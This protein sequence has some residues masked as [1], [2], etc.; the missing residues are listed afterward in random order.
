MKTKNI[1][2]LVILSVLCILLLGCEQNSSDR[3]FDVQNTP[4][5][6]EYLVTEPTTTATPVFYSPYSADEYVGMNYSS[7]ESVLRGAGFENITLSA[8]DDID[9][10]S[11][12]KDG[13]VESVL[14]NNSFNYT[15][16]TPFS[17]DE[18]ILIIYHNI[19][20]ISVPVSSSQAAC[21]NYMDIGKLL[22]D[23]GFVNISTDEY[24]D[25][26]AS[27]EYQTVLTADGNEILSNAQIPFDCPIRVVGHYSIPKY[28]VKIDIDFDANQIFN[29]YDVEVSLDGIGLG[30]L[31]HGESGSYNMLL[32][33]GTYELTFANANNNQISGDYVLIVT[34]E[35]TVTCRI[36][37][38]S[39]TIKVVE[40]AFSQDVSSEKILMPF[41]SNYCLRRDYKTI[42]AELKA[43]GFTE[44]TVSPTGQNYWTPSPVDTVVGVNVNGNSAFN[45]DEAFSPNVPIVVY[46]HMADFS[47]AQSVICVTE[48]ETFDIPFTMTSGDSLESLYFEIESPDVLIRNSDGSFTALT[49]GTT[50]VTVFSGNHVCSTCMVEVAEIVVPIESISFVNNEIDVVV[51][52]TFIPKYSVF[53]KNANYMDITP[54]FTSEAIQHISDNQFYANSAGDF[55]I[56]YYQD[57]RLLGVCIVHAHI[58][59]IEEVIIHDGITEMFIGESVDLSFS[60]VPENA[61]CKDIVVTS[62]NPDIV[63][64][65]FDDRGSTIATLSGLSAGDAT[66]LISTPNGK[67]YSTTVT[68]K[69]IPPTKI[70]LTNTT[71]ISRIEIGT[72]IT[73]AVDW[74]P[75]N[76]TVKE[77]TWESSNTDVIKINNDGTILAVGIGTARLTATHKSGVLGTIVLTVEPT[78]VTS[79]QLSAD[80]DFSKPFV[81]GD[82]FTI[83][84]S[85]I[86]TN[87]T[88][89][90]LVYTSS[91]ET[92]VKVSSKGVVTAVGAGTATVT[93][94]SPDGP[95]SSFDITVSAAPQK[96]RIK[97]SA[98]LVD[99]NHVG[100]RWSKSFE[101]NDTVFSSGSTTILYPESFL[102]I[103]LAITE[104]DENPDYG[105]YYE[106]I[107]YSEELCKH[108]LNITDTVYV[109]ENGGRY[110]GNRA[111]WKITITITPIN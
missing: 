29:K 11:A 64:V 28:A 66:I 31:S 50:T 92:I 71:S 54:V 43:L 94:A 16:S 8:I 105:Q 101:V 13:S 33:A 88:C 74:T 51:G 103:R 60:L 70:A 96:F 100:S 26:N 81:K 63:E 102:S 6:T 56:S 69:E 68:V 79:I 4:S 21:L 36:S 40:S 14:I 91:D 18:E 86:P 34:S 7:V 85:I 98:S 46:Y 95:S 57:D 27:V 108:G 97:W 48:K 35:T 75:H 58:V 76:V 10:Q 12:I 32:E 84:T 45:R 106:R 3:N 90:D 49:P 53:P 2:I 87:S 99:S 39:D 104:N 67:Q 55:E 110:S 52:S 73:I 72:P 107:P 61:T 62:S 25:N 47:F 17:K 38:K 83:C 77:V 1:S 93:V 37:C 42:V 15:R 44:I 22:F 89:K 82:K 109:R 111:E 5:K 9:S 19:P 41:S 24:Y 23:S 65:S 59:D 20:K 80:W 78:L 30:A